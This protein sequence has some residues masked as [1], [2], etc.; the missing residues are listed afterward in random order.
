MYFHQDVPTCGLDVGRAC[1]C[2]SLANS[3]TLMGFPRIAPAV[4]IATAKALSAF[5]SSGLS[6]ESLHRL[7]ARMGDLHGFTADLLHPCSVGALAPGMLM[8]VRSIALLNAQGGTMYEDADHDSH[9]VMVES[10]DGDIVVINPD[11]R[12]SGG[13][14]VADRWGRMTIATGQLGDVWCSSRADGT[15]TSCAAVAIRRIAT[16]RI[17]QIEQPSVKPGQAEQTQ[18]VPSPFVK[19]KRPKKRTGKKSTKPEDESS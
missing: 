4:I 13:G 5:D 6:P 15:H 17:S 11:R 2:V 14:F 7:C 16:E 18:A 8:Y 10:V 12:R 19:N 1:G 3:I 9:I